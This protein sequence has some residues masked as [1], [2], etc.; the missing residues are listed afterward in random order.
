MVCPP[1]RL[2]A[3][4]APA[5]DACQRRLRDRASKKIRFRCAD[6]LDSF[7]FRNARCPHRHVG[8]RPEEFAVAPLNS[9][10]KGATREL[11]PVPRDESMFE[12]L[13]LWMR[14]EGGFPLVIPGNRANPEQ[15][16]EGY[17]L[18]GNSLSLVCEHNELGRVYWNVVVVSFVNLSHQ[19]IA[20]GVHVMWIFAQVGERAYEVH[21]IMVP[22]AE[23]YCLV[24]N[25]AT[26]D[27][28]VRNL[29]KPRF[30]NRARYQS[31]AVPE[32][33]QQLLY[34]HL[35]YRVREG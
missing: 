19:E 17:E 27:A 1:D 10:L 35:E 28:G 26:D 7:A 8:G 33:L 11:L 21:R 34:E 32:N 18:L 20:P 14:S 12:D 3:V 30:E 13:V 31:I 15:S 5:N 4:F 24:Q 29:L 16:V 2:P 22:E 9:Q 25:F 6:F 23:R